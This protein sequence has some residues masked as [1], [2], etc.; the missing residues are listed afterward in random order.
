MAL[1]V[2]SGL[3]CCASALAGRTVAWRPA[4]RGSRRGPTASRCSSTAETSAA[5]QIESVTVQ[6]LAAR[7]EGPRAG[8]RAQTGAAAGAGT[9]YLTVEGQRALAANEDLLPYPVRRLID[10]DRRGPR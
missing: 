3:P 9:A 4:R 6:A 10:L 7:E 8:R 1:T 5:R 2:R